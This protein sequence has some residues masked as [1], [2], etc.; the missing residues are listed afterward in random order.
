MEKNNVIGFKLKD[1]IKRLEEFPDYYISKEGK[2][3]SAKFTT[4]ALMSGGL[5]EIIPKEHNRGYWE[6]GIYTKDSTGKRLRKWKRLHCLVAEAFIPK[7]SDWDTKYYEVN[8]KN[9]NK[10]DN[11]VDNLEYV[12]R[13]E[14]IR[15]SYHV[16]GR[17]KALRPIIWDGVKYG[18][19]IECAKKNGVSANSISSTL[20]QGRKTY[21]G[22]KIKYATKGYVKG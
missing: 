12:D 21:K 22:K 8:H 1:E 9:G 13:S 2:L 18:S 17:E 11:R 6:A 20:S 14:N 4:R 10:K 3:Y 5:Y 15:H 19:I 16:L 7:P